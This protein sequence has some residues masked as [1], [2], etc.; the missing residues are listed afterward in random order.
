MEMRRLLT[1]VLLVGALPA[2]SRADVTADVWRVRSAG[3]LTVDGG[4]FLG[5]ATALGPS[6]SSGLGFGVTR[7]DRFAWEARASWSTATESSIPW[8]VTQADLRLRGGVALQRRLGRARVGLR[9]GLGPTIVHETR[10]RNQGMRAGLSGADLETSTYSALPAGDLEGLVAVHVFGP[11][12]LALS[13]GPSASV[14]DGS[15]HGGW[16][17]QLGVGWQ[18]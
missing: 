9:L 5:P 18:P 17:A 14:H 1:A 13:G 15:A 3:S 6:L 4:L 10:V 8:T 16:I 12:L 11:W 2:E 7:G